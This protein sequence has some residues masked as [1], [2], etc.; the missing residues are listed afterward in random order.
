MLAK[1]CS[2]MNKPDGQMLLPSTQEAVLGFVRSL[3]VRKVPGIG[4][5]MEKVLKEGLGARTVEDLWRLRALPP[6]H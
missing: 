3:P 6:C 2:D 5:V 1:V 4:K